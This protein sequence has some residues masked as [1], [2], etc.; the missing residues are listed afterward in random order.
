MLF[1]TLIASGSRAASRQDMQR[2]GFF[3]LSVEADVGPVIS[4]ALGQAVRVRLE[5]SLS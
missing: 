3:R 5:G 1:I 2:V 4:A